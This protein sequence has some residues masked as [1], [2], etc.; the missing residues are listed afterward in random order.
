[1]F[2][3]DIILIII[4]AGFAFYGLF[5]GF[6]QT[7]GTLFGIIIGIWTALR[8]YPMIFN[9]TENLFFGY[10]ITAKIVIFIILFSLVSRLVNFIFA[11]L[12]RAF[13]LISIIPFLKPANQLV[14]AVFGFLMGSLILGLVL[15]IALH[16]VVNISWLQNNLVQS[17]IASFLLKF[18]NILMPLFPNLLIKFKSFF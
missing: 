8:C 11:L 5:F 18:I 14:G 10:N 12:N 1:M 7:L 15:I 9:W 13:N 17:K 6:I 3:F 4:L 2:I 16:Y